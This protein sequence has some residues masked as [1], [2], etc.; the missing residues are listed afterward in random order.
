MQK[1]VRLPVQ[2]WFGT[3]PMNGIDKCKCNDVLEAISKTSFL[4]C[5]V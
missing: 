2:I 3:K 4:F 1:A 5:C